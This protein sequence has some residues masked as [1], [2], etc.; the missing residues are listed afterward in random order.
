MNSMRPSQVSLVA[1]VLLALVGLVSAASAQTESQTRDPADWLDRMGQAVEQLNFRGTMVHIYR[2][3]ADSSKIVHR[4]ADGV[5]T[6]RITALEDNGREIIRSN[7]TVTCI[8]PDQ[9]MILVEHQEQ[10]E[11]DSSPVMGQLPS[12]MEFDDDS[13]EIV[14]LGPGRAAGRECEVLSVHP[15][16]GFRYGYRLWIDRATAML[17]KSQLMDGQDK[18][19]EEILF[20][21]ISFP[22]RISAREVEPTL[23]IDSYT[24]SR[25]EPILNRQI[26]LDD[27]DWRATDLPPGFVLSAVRTRKATEDRGSME[28]LVYTDGLASVSVFIETGISATEEVEGLSQIGAA[29]AYTTTLH[30]CL[31]TAVG[32]VPERT[33]KMI[34]LSIRPVRTDH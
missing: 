21:E 31:I 4:V 12:F 25:P 26:R 19:V 33:A 30:G 11:R 13:Y 32:D 14:M 3:E 15:R 20:T 16:D 9:K 24:W 29:R 6:E 28:Q 18:V 23:D 1:A 8:F 7:G 10:L 27:V 22:A 34:A 2:G 17:L 5:V